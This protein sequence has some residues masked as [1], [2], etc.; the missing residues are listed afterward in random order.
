LE[1]LQEVLLLGDGRQLFAAFL[2]FGVQA[3]VV[4]PAVGKLGQA[5]VFGLQGCFLLGKFFLVCQ[6]L[7]VFL[8]EAFQVIL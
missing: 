2:Q 4:L 6:E 5:L 7:V 3:L 1:A 8:S